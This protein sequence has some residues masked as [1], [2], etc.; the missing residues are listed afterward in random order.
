MPTRILIAGNAGNRVYAAGRV[1]LDTGPDDVGGPYTALMRTERFSPA[2]EDGLVHFRRVMLRV[3]HTG[4]FSGTLRCYV[5]EAQTQ[6]YVGSTATDQE[7]AFS[8][9]AP[10]T[11]PD[12]ALVEMDISA[13]GTF[14]QVEL[15]VDS[16]AITG[17]FLPESIIVGARVLRPGRQRDAS[18]T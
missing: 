1:G 7:L 15:E 8:V 13:V 11:S 2:G 5:D 16:D 4:A 17:V 9:D 14:I 12:E 3:W 10:V 18:V 6:Y